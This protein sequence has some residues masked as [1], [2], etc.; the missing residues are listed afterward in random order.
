ML[1]AL[2]NNTDKKLHFCT[3]LKNKPAPVY[4]SF[5]KTSGSQ[6]MGINDAT[7]SLAGTCWKSMVWYYVSWYW[8]K[9]LYKASGF[10][11]TFFKHNR[12]WRQ[13]KR[14]FHVLDGFQ[15]LLPIVNEVC[16][17]VCLSPLYLPITV[18]AYVRS[19]RSIKH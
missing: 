7:A 15:F 9:F 8:G 13:E 14:L 18:C 5:L 6:H 17:C 11:V 19:E 3:K 1:C 10:R 16:V 12:S 2:Q 4:L